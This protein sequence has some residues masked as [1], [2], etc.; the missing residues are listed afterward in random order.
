MKKL[1]AVIGVAALALTTVNAQ[2]VTSRGA[3]A[4]TKAGPETWYQ[5]IIGFAQGVET[6]KQLSASICPTYAPGLTLADGTK[7]EWGGE[8]TLGYPL[9][10]SHL[11]VQGGIAYLANEFYSG[12]ATVTPN[13]DVQL[14]GKSVTFY[15]RAGGLIP[16]SGTQENGD[17]GLI[18]GA[19]VMT[20]LWKP[21]ANTALSV[22]VAYDRI[23][24]V[25]N[26]NRYSGGLSFN[27]GF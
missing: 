20:T 7:A 12:E 17:V 9:V 8:A 13:F 18:V 21:S 1:L 15:G 4:K 2:F 16:I 22:F 25:L 11:M 23:T 14:F 6:N 3:P 5:W 19:G 26:V 10:S 24:P 27:V